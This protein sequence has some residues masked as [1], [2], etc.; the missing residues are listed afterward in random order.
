MRLYGIAPPVSS[1]TLVA[2]WAEATTSRVKG[3]IQ[4]VVD[5]NPFL[6]GALKKHGEDDHVVDA[7]EHNDFVIEIA[8]PPDFPRFWATKPPPIKERIC[9]VQEQLEP[10]FA[11]HTIGGVEHA[12]ASGGPLFRVV[13]MK[14]PSDMMAYVVEV[15][16]IIAD[17]ATY[18]KLLGLIDCAVNKR[19]VPV[20]EWEAATASIPI[21][22]HWNDAD[23]DLMMTG[24]LPGFVHKMTNVYVAGTPSER[25]ATVQVVD[26]KSAANLKTEFKPP[27][28]FSFLSTNDLIQAACCELADDDA[29]S[30]MFANLRGRMPNVTDCKAG[31]F[32]VG[33]ACVHPIATSLRYL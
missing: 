12:I 18:Y 31:N 14:L 26:K 22:V 19:P 7:R 17:G 13:L 23:K 32:E 25:T 3:A 6:S 10:L 9:T 33:H 8:G 4:R 1:I 27:Q 11:E 20:L 21:P 28:G 5:N 2:G 29:I 15:N 16:H 30:I 24:W